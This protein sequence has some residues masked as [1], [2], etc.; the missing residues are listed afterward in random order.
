VYIVLRLIIRSNIGLAFRAIGQNFDSAQASGVN[1][2]RYKLLNFTLS[3]AC[4]GFFGG[5]YAHFVGIVTPDIMDTGHTLEVMALSFIG[6]SGSLVGGIFAA[7]LLVPV[8]D[9]LKKL[10]EYRLIIYGMLLILVMIFYP[11]GL[12]GLYQR[13]VLILKNLRGKKNENS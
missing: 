12:S 4:A 8:F 1:P 2:T 3:C 13:A 7:F 9:S 10:M 5:F 6:G 11:A